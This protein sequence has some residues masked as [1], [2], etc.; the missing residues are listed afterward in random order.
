MG[1]GAAGHQRL[2]ERWPEL[3]ASLYL[4]VQT[5]RVEALWLKARTALAAGTP[6]LLEAADRDARALGRDRL[7]GARAMSD[8]LR[9]GLAARRAEPE[10][11]RAALASAL[12]GF[13]AAS[14]ALHAAVARRQ[15]GELTGGDAGRA[16]IEAAETWMAGQRIASPKRMTAML[17]PGFAE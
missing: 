6:A 8:L 15:L 11:A 9:A 7:P 10:A 4:R 12:A 14:M 17:V 3:E 1:D 5:V 13:E 2:L 16:L